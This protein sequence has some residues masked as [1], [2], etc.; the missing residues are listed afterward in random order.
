MK[1]A[2]VN[3]N[4]NLMNEKTIAMVPLVADEDYK[5]SSETGDD[6]T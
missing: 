3:L 5:A 6:A 4:T 1:D 2:L